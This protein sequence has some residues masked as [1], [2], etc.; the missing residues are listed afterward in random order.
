MSTPGG[1]GLRALV[2]V[3][4]REAVAD[5]VTASVRDAL[6]GV[7]DATAGAPTTRPVSAP[8]RAGTAAAPVSA[9]AARPTP[10]GRSRVEDVRMSCDG[11]LN[12][13]ARHLL[14]LF[15]NPKNRQDL[16]TGRHRFRFAPGQGSGT[17][18]TRARRVERG[19]VT[20]R[21]II[22]AAEAGESLLLARPAVLTPLAREKAR[23]LGVHLEKEQ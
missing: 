16:R 20:E 4:V 15:E 14:E 11:D 2:A 1:D 5:M 6:T 9:P 21:Q 12:A 7:T 18:A 22:A 17:R 19:A 3:A 8:G 23:A 13:F 10:P